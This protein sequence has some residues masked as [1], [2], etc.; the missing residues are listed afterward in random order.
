MSAARQVREEYT[1]AL[2]R[3][4]LPM[5]EA[6]LEAAHVAALGSALAS[7]AAKRFGAAGGPGMRALQDALVA[8]CEKELAALRTANTLRSGQVTRVRVVA[9]GHFAAGGCSAGRSC[10]RI[11]RVT[12]NRYLRVDVEQGQC[13]HHTPIRTFA[14]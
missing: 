6:Q 14:Q 10:L 13:P 1:A 12:K 8:G 11:G 2:E 5:E 7:F 4:P 3:A 9:H